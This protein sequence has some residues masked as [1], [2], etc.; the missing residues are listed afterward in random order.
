MEPIDLLREVPTGT[1]EATAAGLFLIVLALVTFAGL[2]YATY[3]DRLAAKKREEKS[4]EWR[5]AA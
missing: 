3:A 1:P 4:M 2:L 5:E